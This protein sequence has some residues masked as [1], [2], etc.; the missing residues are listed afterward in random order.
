MLRAGWAGGGLGPGERG[1]RLPVPTELKRDRAGLGW[2]PGQRPRIT[3]FGP[4]DAAAV[5]GPSP[6]GAEGRDGSRCRSR[7]R[8]RSEAEERAWEIQ[9]REYM[10]R[11][12]PPEPPRRARRDPP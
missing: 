2:G 7:C 6:R 11:W 1:R 4:G 12:D 5:A 10:E 9:L 3:H 8:F